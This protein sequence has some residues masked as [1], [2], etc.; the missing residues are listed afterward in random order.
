MIVFALS[1]KPSKI[2]HSQ[3]LVLKDTYSF[4]HIWKNNTK[5]DQDK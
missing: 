2:K 3:Q 1:G 5:D 4:T